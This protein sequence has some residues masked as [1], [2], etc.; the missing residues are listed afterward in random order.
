MHQFEQALGYGEGQGSLACYGPRGHK[1][2]D[3]T[4]WLN[5]NNWDAKV[6]VKKSKALMGGK[7]SGPSITTQKAVYW[8]IY[9]TCERLV[10]ILVLSCKI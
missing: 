8:T 2:S 6:M 10:M 4:E 1:K 3:M 7:Y 5:N 9:W